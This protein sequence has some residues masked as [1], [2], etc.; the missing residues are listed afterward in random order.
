MEILAVSLK[1]A[2]RRIGV[3]ERTVINLI[4][5]KELSSRKIGRRR[6]VLVKHLQEFLRRDHPTF[7]SQGVE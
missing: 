6:V 5:A 3:C 1:E 2:G 4:N 7:S